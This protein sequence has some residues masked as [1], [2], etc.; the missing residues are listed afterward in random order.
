[1]RKL[2]LDTV[3]VRRL[4][5]DLINHSESCFTSIFTILELL[6]GISEKEYNIRKTVLVNLFKSGIEIDWR[7]PIE[8]IMKSFKI[9]ER[10]NSILANDIKRIADELVASMTYADFIERNKKL[11][12]D[13]N[14]L[15]YF[16]QTLSAQFN[17]SYSQKT[18]D[19]REARG[20]DKE[21]RFT[22]VKEKA[23]N[24][25]ADFICQGLLP[26]SFARRSQDIQK[27]YDGSVDRFIEVWLGYYDANANLINEVSTNDWSDV[28]HTT[29][30]ESKRDNVFVSDDKKIR[31]LLNALIPNSAISVDE[32]RIGR[33]KVQN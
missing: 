16:D 29:Y 9:D 33:A 6:S 26:S 11:Q 28:L 27:E 3:A 18:A 4:S 21:A 17:R 15:T 2:Y 22:P 10:P 25:L 31:N 20:N 5:K 8:V 24:A 23:I 1:M 12:P 14:L 13:V 7:M 32:F 19:I 30:L